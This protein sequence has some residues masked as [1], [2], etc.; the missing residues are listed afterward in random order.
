MSV[1][2]EIRMRA[3]QKELNYKNF[4]KNASKNTEKHLDRRPSYSVVD[5]LKT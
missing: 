1:T 5:D 2:G 4:E 3:I